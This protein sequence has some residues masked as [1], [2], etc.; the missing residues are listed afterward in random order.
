[1]KECKSNVSILQFENNYYLCKEYFFYISYNSICDGF[2]DCPN[3]DDEHGCLSRKQYY[4]K[5]SFTQK[6]IPLNKVCDF[7]SDCENGEDEKFCCN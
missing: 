1:M 7:V 4:Y 3:G 2:K 5:C 6:F